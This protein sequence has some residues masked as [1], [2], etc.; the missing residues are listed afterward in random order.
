MAGLDASTPLPTEIKLHQVVA[1]AGDRVR[2]R[3]GFRCRTNTCACIRRRPKC[4]A[5]GRA[6]KCCR[7]ARRRW[8]SRRRTGRPLRGPARFS[9]GHDTG[10]YSWDYLHDLGERQDELWQRYLERLAGGRR[11]PRRGRRRSARS[12]ETNDT[13]S[14]YER[15]T[16]T[17]RPARARRIRFGRPQV[18]PDERPDVGRPAPAVEALRRRGRRRAARRSACSISRAAPAISRALFAERVGAA[19]ACATD[20]NGAMLAAGRDRLLD[21]GSLLPT[22]QCDAETCRSPTRAF[23][24]VPIAFGLRNMTHKE[25]ALAEMRRV[26]RPGGAA[27][28]ARVLA[29]RGAAGAAPTTGTVSMCC[30]GSASSSPA[31]TRATA[32]WPN[33]SACTRTRR[34]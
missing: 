22:V 5:T 12:H 33:R 19:A 29:R 27:A 15:S 21:A 18:R 8:R 10:I 11:K 14:A 1:R 4:A 3:Q 24:C 25:A 7:S 32:I 17:R 2:R 16:R 9:D 20:I 26:L 23:D 13:N 6:R 28:G 34:R 31:T 30:R